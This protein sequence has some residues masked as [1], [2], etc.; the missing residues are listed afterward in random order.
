MKFKC[1]PNNGATQQKH[2][3]MVEPARATC[4]LLFI[5]ALCAC[6]QHYIF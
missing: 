3:N 4:E 6:N 2:L 1:Q 5:I